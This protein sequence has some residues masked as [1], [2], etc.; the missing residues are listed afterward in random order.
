MRLPVDARAKKLVLRCPCGKSKRS[1]AATYVAT[2]IFDYACFNPEC[3]KHWR[4]FV[5]PLKASKD[6]VVRQIEWTQICPYPHFDAQEIEM[7]WAM[8]SK[9]VAS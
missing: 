2:D 1:V 8:E 7:R 9:A 3:L 5:R 4:V 6:L